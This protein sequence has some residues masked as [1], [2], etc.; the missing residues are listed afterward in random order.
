MHIYINYNWIPHWVWWHLCT[1][2]VLNSW[3][4]FCKIMVLWD[5]RAGAPGGSWGHSAPKNQPHS[6]AGLHL[7]IWFGPV[8]SHGFSLVWVISGFWSY[9]PCPRK[10][11]WEFVYTSQVPGEVWYPLCKLPLVASMPFTHLHSPNR[12]QSQHR[13]CPVP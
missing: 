7:K 6:F 11:P 3:P 12:L 9:G 1:G 8:L 4:L 10:K 2:T 13:Y 5:T